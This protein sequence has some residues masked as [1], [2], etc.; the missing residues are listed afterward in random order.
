M[1][2]PFFKENDSGYTEHTM[3]NTWHIS[4]TCDICRK[5]LEI[6]MGVV[7]EITMGIVVEITMGTTDHGPWT[8]DH[9]PWTIYA[10]GY[11][12]RGMF[13]I[14]NDTF[15]RSPAMMT[16]TI[17]TVPKFCTRG[18][19]EQPEIFF[20]DPIRIGICGLL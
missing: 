7:V 2:T 12:H 1:S 10:N 6:A 17:R 5:I 20:L 16:T 11:K 3:T 9:E 14:K 19:A 13:F 18:R 4:N 15:M 8:M